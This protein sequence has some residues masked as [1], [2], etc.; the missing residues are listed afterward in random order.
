MLDLVYVF[1]WALLTALATGL[2]VV[3]FMFTSEFSDRWICRCNAMA[4]GAVHQVMTCLSAFLVVSI[5]FFFVVVRG[6]GLPQAGI[7]CAISCL[8]LVD[9]VW[10]LSSCRMGMMG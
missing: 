2:G 8:R 4:A 10:L 9:G 1:V 6:G 3:P 5:C 7:S